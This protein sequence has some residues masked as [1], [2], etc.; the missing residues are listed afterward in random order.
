MTYLTYLRYYLKIIFLIRV[1]NDLVGSVI[2]WRCFKND[3]RDV[4]VR[5]IW[6]VWNGVVWSRNNLAAINLLISPPLWRHILVSM[7]KT[8][9]GRRII[10]W[11]KHLILKSCFPMCFFFRSS[12]EHKHCFGARVHFK[13][14]QNLERF[15]CSTSA[16]LVVSTRLC[17]LRIL[18]SLDN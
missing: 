15:R 5:G 10:V 12:K 14:S 4:M 11:R 3:L 7:A 13:R 1:I 9:E 8:K 16:I 18:C 6:V 2:T 17:W